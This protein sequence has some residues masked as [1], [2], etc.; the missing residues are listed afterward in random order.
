MLWQVVAYFSNLLLLFAASWLLALLLNEPV[1]F[2]TRQNWPQMVAIGVVY[3]GVCAVFAG[4]LTIILPDLITQTQLFISNLG[5]LVSSVETALNHVF[6]NFGLRSLDLAQFS[7]QLQSVGGE[8]LKNGLNIITG[9]AN[10]LIQV[11]LLLIISFSILAGRD[12]G[13]PSYRSGLRKRR[14][15]GQP[16]YPSLWHK[17]PRRYRRRTEIVRLNFERNFGTFLGGQLLVA[18]I[19]GIVTGVVM[20]ATG[21]D[22]ALTTGVICGVIMIIPFFGGPLSLLP[23]LLIAFSKPG[24]VILVMLVLFIIQTAL[25]N[26]VLPKL[27]GKSSGFGAV[28][29]LF[30]LLAGAQIGGLW[31]VLLAVPIAGVI[32]GVGMSMLN[33][34]LARNNPNNY[35]P[36][37]S[38]K[39]TINN[40]TQAEETVEQTIVQTE[41]GSSE[42][43][44]LLSADDV[45]DKN[46]KDDKNSKTDISDKIQTAPD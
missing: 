44:N 9:V 1:K 45:A 28:A 7:S 5:G 46:D 24:P 30:L 10:F 14:K 29:T 34:T 33:E 4:F 40:P 35:A 26:I 11:L 20:W 23:P 39:T 3:L 25:L 2:L 27:V 43:Q 16:H 41:I 6:K 15:R 18:I 36:I 12:Y 8:V 42:L 37:V 38:V 31:G 21:Y 19:H 13:D 32:K 22:Y 17:L